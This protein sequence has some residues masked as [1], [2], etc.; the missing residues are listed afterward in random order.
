[1]YKKHLRVITDTIRKQ[2]YTALAVIFS[3]GPRKTDPGPTFEQEKVKV[4]ITYR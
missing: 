4:S 1:M 2:T 3:K